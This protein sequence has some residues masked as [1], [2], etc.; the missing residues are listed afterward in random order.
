[1]LGLVADAPDLAVGDV[2]DGAVDRAQPRRAQGDRLDRARGLVVEVDDVADAE[3][4]LD[5][6]EDAGQ[7]VAHQRLRA[8]AERDAEDAG[9]GQQRPELMPTSPRIMKPATM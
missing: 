4:V 3:L 5:Q 7:E 8:E 6:D 2:P 1:M 9:A